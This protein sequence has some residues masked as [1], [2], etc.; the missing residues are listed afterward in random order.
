AGDEYLIMLNNFGYYTGTGVL[1]GGFTIDFT[2]STATFNQ[3]PAP[4]LDGIEPYCDLSQKVTVKLNQLIKCSSIAP[5]GS[6]FTLSPSGSIISA[7]GNN[8]AMALGG[9]SDE[10][11]LTFASPLPTG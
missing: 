4:K 9:Y 5:D 8:C 1:G 3:P 11:T 10:I 6:D 2:G 7:V